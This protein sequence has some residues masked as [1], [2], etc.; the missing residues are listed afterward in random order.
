MKRRASPRKIPMMLAPGDDVVEIITRDDGG[1]V[2]KE[3][4]PASGCTTRQYS[5]SSSICEKCFRRT[6][7]RARGI[8]PSK[9]GSMITPRITG[10]RES[11]SARQAK[12]SPARPLTWLL[13]RD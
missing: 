5:R 3:E 10:S 11:R 12:I 1:A 8:S 6:A 13:S 2:R 4:D 7:K 9:I